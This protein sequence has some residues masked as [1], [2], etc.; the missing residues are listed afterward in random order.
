MQ[1][2]YMARESVLRSDVRI[3]ICRVKDK[4]C[5]RDP[6]ETKRGVTEMRMR[7]TKESG[8]YRVK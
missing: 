1:R 5:A 4:I 8:R 6:E 2:S 3:D 7:I